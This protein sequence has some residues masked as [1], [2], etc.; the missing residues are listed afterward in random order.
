MFLNK[1]L[2]ISS[3]LNLSLPLFLGLIPNLIMPPYVFLID[4][5]LAKISFLN[6]IFIKSY[7]GK[8]FGNTSLSLNQVKGLGLITH[9]VAVQ[10]HGPSFHQFPLSKKPQKIETVQSSSFFKESGPYS[11]PSD[12]HLPGDFRSW[13]SPQTLPALF[14]DLFKHV[15]RF[16]NLKFAVERITNIQST[17]LSSSEGTATIH[18]AFK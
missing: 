12:D 5:W 8:T 15:E 3:I 1:F 16:R 6:L 10:L 4:V 14:I 9:N 2:N 13:E 18:F 11:L 17:V 7:R